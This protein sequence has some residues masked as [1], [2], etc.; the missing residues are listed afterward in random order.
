MMSLR[1]QRADLISTIVVIG[2]FLSVCFHYVLHFYFHREYPYSTFLSWPFDHQSDFTHVYAATRGMDPYHYQGGVYGNY[3][4]VTYAA[5]LL[6]GSLRGGRLLFLALSLAGIVAF[7]YRRSGIAR[8]PQINR[9]AKVRLTFILTVMSYP[10]LFE[11]DRA[12]FESLTFLL[13]AACVLLIGRGKFGLSVLPLAFAVAMKGYPIVFLGLYLPDKKYREAASVVV[14]SAALCLAGLSVWHGGLRQNI[15]GFSTGLQIFLNDYVIRGAGTAGT[16]LNCSLFAPLGLLDS[17]PTFIRQALL[18]FDGFVLVCGGFLLWLIAAKKA[19]GWKLQYLLAAAALLLTPISYD[20]K[21][22]VLF[23]PLASFLNS[24][25]R[26]RLD[27]FYCASFGAMLIPK[28]YLILGPG[29]VFVNG[30]SSSSLLEPLILLVTA[31]LIARDVVAQSA[32]KTSGETS[33][34]ESKEAPHDGPGT[35]SHNP[36]LS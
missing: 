26:E 33:A 32:N 22:L 7:F 21:L 31:A 8:D 36:L 27:A 11:M 28:D 12:N 20:Y 25:R 24:A 17:N 14:L 29:A 34:E 35:L 15:S 18:Y 4:P 19:A 3:F 10:V 1:F 5:A 30:V 13:I 16:R 23:I 6:F 9:L 2:F